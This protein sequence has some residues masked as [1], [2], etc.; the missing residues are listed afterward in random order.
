VEEVKTEDDKS[1]EDDMLSVLK[2]LKEHNKKFSFRKNKSG[3]YEVIGCS[4]TQIEVRPMYMDSYDVIF[5]LDGT[6][7]EKKLNLDLKGVKEFIKAKL[8]SKLEN[9]T[10]SSFNKAANTTEDVTKKTA[11]LPSTKQND[12]KKVGDT[13]NDN[14]DYSEAGR[15]KNVELAQHLAHFLHNK[16][17]NVVVSLVSPYKDQRDEFKNKLGDTINEF[18][19][20]TSEIRGTLV[21][22]PSIR[23][24]GH[25]D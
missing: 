8:T 10:K 17:C 12:I 4:P 2:M 15:R 19:V 22:A 9:Y 25:A 20:H 16:G 14:K 21:N 6:D 5:M 11:G 1:V 7:R 24:L 13:K 23:R 3:N 18:Y